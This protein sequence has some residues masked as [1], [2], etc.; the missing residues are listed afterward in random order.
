[1]RIFRETL[2]SGVIEKCAELAEPYA[3]D[4]KKRVFIFC[5]SRST[6]LFERAV[7]ARCG[8]SFSVVVTSFARYVQKRS[9]EKKYLDKTQATLAVAEIIGENKESLTRLKRNTFSTA[10]HVFEL[11]SQLKSAKISPGDLDSVIL[12]ESSALTYKLGDIRLIY[13]L[14]EDF[15]AKNGLVDDCDVL[16]DLPKLFASDPSLKGGK[17]IVAGI[18]NFTART[19]DAVVAL[20]TFCD[21]DCVVVSYDGES[22]L[23]ESFDKLLKLFPNAKIY[24][25]DRALSVP[26]RIIRDRLFDEGRINEEGEY[27]EE[28]AIVETQD[29]YEEAR[30]VAR[31]IRAEI[32]GSGKRYRDFSVACPDVARYEGAFRAAFFDQGLKLYAD[33]KRKLSSHPAF[34]LF[35]SLVRLKRYNA[36][37]D[38]A[39]AF[40]ENA[41]AFTREKSD[42]FR[43]YVLQNPVK[44]YGLKDD[45]TDEVADGV[46]AKILACARKMP[47]NATIAQFI[48]SVRSVFEC[49]GVEENALAL[50]EALALNGE[51]AAA[52][53]AEQGV[54][55]FSEILE[56]SGSLFGGRKLSLREFADLISS[57]AEACEISV[58]PQYND[59]VFL[60]DYKSVGLGVAKVLFCVG[61]TGDTPLVRRDTAL[62]SDKE[63]VRLDGFRLFV[64]PKIS[65]VNKRERETV[66]TTLMSF[67]DKL[68][69][70]Y[71]LKGADGVKAEKSAVVD[72][73]ARAFTSG[74]KTP[75]VD[76]ENVSEKY[77]DPERYSSRGAAMKA[78]LEDADDFRSKIA[79]DIAAARAFYSY[80]SG[81]DPS[82]Y[83][84]LAEAAEGVPFP[85]ANAELSFSGG[86]SP[87][88]IEAYFACPYA[89]LLS[90]ILK[91]KES[92]DN[93]MKSYEIGNA[94]HRV[95]DK[96]LNTDISDDNAAAVAAGVCDE[97][98]SSPEFARYKGDPAGDFLISS[99]RS[100]AVK[101]CEKL[102]KDLKNSDFTVLGTELYVGEGGDFPPIELETDF[103]KIELGGYIDRVDVK[104][105]ENLA[106][107]IDYKTGSDVAGKT[108]VAK[109][110]YGR[111]VQIYLYLCAL[112]GAGFAPA[113]LHYMALNDN[114]REKDEEKKSYYGFVLDDPDV[115]RALDHGFK[116]RGKSEDYGLGPKGGGTVTKKTLEDMIEYAKRVS[117]VGAEEM[118]AGFFA[119]SPCEKACDY[120]KYR[121]SCR[122]DADNARLFREGLTLKKDDISIAIEEE[123]DE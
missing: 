47:D 79:S 29:I 67:T 36:R 111:I 61:M 82:V 24:D 91:L 117:V 51:D 49:L 6:L 120:C 46:R 99:I 95:L 94:F 16:K 21:L 72:Y 8:G 68:Y 30:F 74:D 11:I 5:E 56:R 58:I 44:R 45:F 39:L 17:A 98:L 27:R 14:Y 121:G 66:A 83:A 118:N 23:N 92:A 37:L 19:L 80:V 73:L 33:V 48:E 96:F 104:T 40:S 34:A 10:L 107:V 50:K 32:V 55:A 41:L 105:G 65:I 25:D 90:R 52:S 3:R 123:D 53:F 97:V 20:N 4:L 116:E 63:L 86:V 38:A 110:Y 106:R 100:E 60:G 77:S 62:L 75:F 70:T 57:A 108:E 35:S 9:P 31:T 103:G 88:L 85:T 26:A 93:Q 109:L 71:P 81:S 78:F 89:A 122:Y 42:A 28:I 113:A 87:S 102:Y 43:N 119:A 115:I 7:C 101:H 18:T 84:T 112:S 22:A 13:G 76:A 54:K 2:P 15:L 59:N 12:G 114:F 69:V 64:E 1:M